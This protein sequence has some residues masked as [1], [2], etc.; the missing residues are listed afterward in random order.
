MMNGNRK[1]FLNSGILGD[2][3]GV[4]EKRGFRPVLTEYLTSPDYDPKYFETFPTAW[5]AAYAFRKVLDL[6]VATG[7][8]SENGAIVQEVSQAVD[9][10]VTLFLLHYFGIV[11][12]SES[13]QSQLQQEYDRDLWLA[14]SG[15]YPSAR[16]EAPRSIKLLQHDQT[17]V[18]A[19]YPEV[20]GRHGS[21]TTLS[22]ITSSTTSCPGFEA[23]EY[24]SL[25]KEKSRRF[26]LISAPLLSTP[27]AAA[28]YRTGCMA[29]VKQTSASESM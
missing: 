6:S 15:T 22:T 26:T 1:E 10:W 3:A 9:E 17:V 14:L 27:C 23:G 5:A 4:A 28:V 24:S 16:E 18:G 12:L 19:Y 8:T 29:S 2:G 25:V 20:I 21:K 11:Y 7:H 13:K